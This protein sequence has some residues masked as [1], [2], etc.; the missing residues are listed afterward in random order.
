[1]A[2][3]PRESDLVT[4]AAVR[5]TLKRIPP[6]AFVEAVRYSPGIN[7]QQFC[8]AYLSGVRLKAHGVT[9]RPY[10]WVNNRLLRA[11]RKLQEEA[12]RINGSLEH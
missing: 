9:R 7:V 4:I 2:D 3:R 11:R 12:S 1:M 5:G 6:R 8:D 10:E